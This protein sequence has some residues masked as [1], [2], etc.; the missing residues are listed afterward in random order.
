M[1]QTAPRFGSW[2]TS[3]R[4]AAPAGYRVAPGGVRVTS[5]IRHAGENSRGG[6]WCEAFALSDELVALSIGDVCGHGA[7]KH[8]LMAAL[9]GQIRVAAGRGC[10][11]AQ[12]LAAANAY[13]CADPSATYATAIFG[14]LSTR[15]RSF[16]FA[17]AGHPA[18]LLARTGGAAYL[19]FPEADFMLGVENELRAQV[20]CVDVPPASLLVLYTDGVTERERE[21]LRGAE[22]LLEAVAFAH[23]VS[24]VPVTEVI[25]RQMS[26]AGPNPDDTAILSVWSVP[27]T[28]SRYRS[29]GRTPARAVR[30]QV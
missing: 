19:E 10:D 16:T 7:D 17:N 9:R 18:P 5:H 6:D 25:G 27:V 26:L 4:L 20:H 23:K 14:L 29:R 1:S 8:P 15:R 22:Q 21:P 11:P 28:N 30:G 12:T 13:L 3:E 2:Q 24:L